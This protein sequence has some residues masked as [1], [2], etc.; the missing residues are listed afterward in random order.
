MP[1]SDASWPP[2]PPTIGSTLSQYR[3]EEKIGGGGM[4][5]VFRA[6]DTRLNRAVAVKVLTEGT[7]A[8]ETSRQRFLREARAACAL[9]HP[10]VVTIH[11]V[12]PPEASISS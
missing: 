12:T 6:V 8:D 2:A 3:L 4:G 9:N 5:V 1:S 7:V 11:E 10:N